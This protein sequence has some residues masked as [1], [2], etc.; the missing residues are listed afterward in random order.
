MQVNLIPDSSKVAAPLTQV[1]SNAFSLAAQTDADSI[2]SYSAPCR[3]EPMTL[4]DS[5]LGLME[6]MPKVLSAINN[7]FS[8]YYV[9]A[10]TRS[11]DVYSYRLLRS[12]DHLKPSRS[13]QGAL[14]DFT[15]QSNARL[16]TPYQ[17]S[18]I[19]VQNKV[20]EMVGESIA[21]ATYLPRFNQMAIESRGNAKGKTKIIARVA[22]EKEKKE[23]DQLAVQQATA[24]L[25]EAVTD[26]T[27]RMTAVAQLPTGGSVKGGGVDYMQ[28][29]H[30]I[31]GKIFEL[32]AS[33]GGSRATVQI[34]VSLNTKFTR[35]SNLVD[36]LAVGGESRSF[37]ERWHGWR[38][39]EL[40]FLQDII[41]GSDLID[42]ELRVGIHDE[43]G[44][45]LQ[46]RENDAGNKVSA[47][48][49][50]K[51]SVG[52]ASGIFVIH[53]RTARAIEARIGGKLED[54]S[55]RSKVFKR[56]YGLLLVVI[57][58]DRESVTVYHRGINKVNTLP[59]SEFIKTRGKD[60][61]DMT[62]VIKLFLNG[63]GPTL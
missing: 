5:E 34:M 26:E 12:I 18:D 31:T 15:E 39:G 23:F 60:G 10:A 22:T 13:L 2:I 46:A 53:A 3:V 14:M 38:S 42:N 47:I 55:T 41:L 37:K 58:P 40:R 19:G 4:V 25:K 30:L 35:P 45:W 32:S 44:A 6:D 56:T 57:D 62:D 20:V 52:S 24:A 8:S 1:I 29:A 48:L 63:T 59:L 9:A 54:M 61:S 33:Y 51:R 49:T 7:L 27:R 17:I 16:T 43:T 36:I 11:L 21:G 28:A 50:G